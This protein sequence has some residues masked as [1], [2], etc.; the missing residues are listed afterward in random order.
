MLLVTV[1]LTIGSVL[2]SRTVWVL[3]ILLRL[4]IEAYRCKLKVK[5]VEE[6]CIVR[7]TNGCRDTV[8]ID[9]S[10]YKISPL[11]D[12]AADN[13]LLDAILRYQVIQTTT[14]L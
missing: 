5:L 4:Q 2:S 11:Q 6:I 10:A 8:K 7:F 1:K 13:G 3:G 9:I 12:C 14:W